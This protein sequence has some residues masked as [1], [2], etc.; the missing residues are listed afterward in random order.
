VFEGLIVQPV[1][2]TSTIELKGEKLDLDGIT[3]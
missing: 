1:P 2:L 3:D